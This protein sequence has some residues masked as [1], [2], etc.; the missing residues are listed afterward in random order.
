MHCQRGS[1]FISGS[2]IQR[3]RL[4]WRYRCVH[5]LGR[6]IQQK[7]IEGPQG[8]DQRNS[9]A[10]QITYPEPPTS[11]VSICLCLIFGFS[12]ANTNAVRSTSVYMGVV[13]AYPV[14]TALSRAINFTGST[15]RSRF[16]LSV[17]YIPARVPF[18]S[19]ATE[20]CPKIHNC[21]HGIPVAQHATT[22]VAH[23]TIHWNPILSYCV[24]VGREG[25]RSGMPFHT[26]FHFLRRL[27]FVY[28]RRG[29]L[30]RIVSIPC[31]HHAFS[32]L[33]TPHPAKPVM[34]WAMRTSQG[35]HCE[36]ERKQGHHIDGA[37][38]PAI[39]DEYVCPDR[40]PHDL[41]DE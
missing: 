13:T 17:A 30:R 18:V 5:P 35:E 14:L 38:P 21:Q 4:L 24:R 40:G 7:L 22:Y 39:L 41:A 10:S 26:L 12:R 3:T 19:E 32:R 33:E 34:P 15:N 9:D 36:L 20:C 16:T 23:D 29:R 31:L 1:P 27:R 37:R 8:P 6:T 25:S 2:L 28:W 11:H